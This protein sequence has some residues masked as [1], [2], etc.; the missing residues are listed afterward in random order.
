MEPENLIKMVNHSS[1]IQTYKVL[2]LF[3]N[4]CAMANAIAVFPVPGGPASNRARPAIFFVLIKSKTIPAACK[5]LE[6][7]FCYITSL[8]LFRSFSAHWLGLRSDMDSNSFQF[9]FFYV[10]EEI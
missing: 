8:S 10:K 1:F 6:K 7:H 2:T 9:H 3:P 4:S 5:R